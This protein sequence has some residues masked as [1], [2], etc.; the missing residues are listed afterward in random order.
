MGSSTGKK[1]SFYINSCS[2]YGVYVVVLCST[3]III[4]IYRQERLIGEIFDTFTQVFRRA[5]FSQY[6][7][8]TSIFLQ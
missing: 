2:N 1:I 5:P 6:L 4:I 7:E 8:S 3:I